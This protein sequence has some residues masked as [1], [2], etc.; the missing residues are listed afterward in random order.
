[1]QN[2]NS[3]T[4]LKALSVSSASK[5][6]NV[7]RYELINLIKAGAFPAETVKFKRK[8]KFIISPKSVDDYNNKLEHG[9]GKD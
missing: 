3:K 8:T 1:M 9:F 6:M 5:L 4:K 2:V 7:S